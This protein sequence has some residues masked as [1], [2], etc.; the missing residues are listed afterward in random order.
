MALGMIE[1]YGFATAIVVADAA[2]KAADVDIV[3]LDKNKPANADAV[4]VP[5]VMVVKM[6]GSV[7][8]VEAGMAAGIEAAKQR[9]L[10]ITSK[11]IARQSP[12]MEW[13]ARLDATGK[14]KLRKVSK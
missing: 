1:C 9:E 11:I 14:D 10:Y 4:E 8:A 3:A 2:S 12:E 6:E 7:A 5:L 13:F